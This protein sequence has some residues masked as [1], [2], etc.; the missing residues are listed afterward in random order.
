VLLDGDATHERNYMGETPL[1]VEAE[2]GHVDVCGLLLERGASVHVPRKNEEN[3]LFLQQLT[4]CVP[5]F[6]ERRATQEPSEPDGEN[7]AAWSRGQ[8]GVR[9]AAQP[10]THPTR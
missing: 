3:P 10:R 5:C 6:W 1:F 9:A 4:T 2:E 7:N 8:A